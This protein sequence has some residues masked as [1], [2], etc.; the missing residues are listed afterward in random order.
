M[1][2]LEI[3]LVNQPFPNY[4]ITGLYSQELNLKNGE[5]TGYK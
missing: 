3:H 1:L 5:N 4:G 2:I